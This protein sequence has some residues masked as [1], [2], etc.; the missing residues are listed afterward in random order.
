[1]W[2]VW[3][4]SNEVYDLL[5]GE[6][7]SYSGN[8]CWSENM[9]LVLNLESLESLWRRWISRSQRDYNNT[10]KEYRQRVCTMT[11]WRGGKTETGNFSGKVECLIQFFSEAKIFVF[12]WHIGDTFWKYFCRTSLGTGG[13]KKFADETI[14]R[15]EQE[16][17]I[18]S[19]C[20]NVANH[21]NSPKSGSK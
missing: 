8:R 9:K 21:W 14:P 2:L 7:S 18:Q 1:M 19:K 17:E 13:R 4:S 5:G 3:V 12:I 20:L 16:V 6:I 11:K 10:G 15:L